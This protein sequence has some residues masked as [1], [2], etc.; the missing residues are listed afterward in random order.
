MAP[1]CSSHA[2]LVI[3]DQ[4]YFDV[5]FFR[6]TVHPDPY[7]YILCPAKSEFDMFPFRAI[8]YPDFYGCVLSVIRV[9]LYLNF[10]IPF[11]CQISFFFSFT[12]L[13]SSPN[14]LY[15]LSLPNKEVSIRYSVCLW[16][17]MP[18]PKIMH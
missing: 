6:L 15:P 17:E 2:I 13:F 9:T 10:G 16:E 5:L 18:S 3:A 8:I 14:Q 12:F 1:N 4:S 7:R 11:V